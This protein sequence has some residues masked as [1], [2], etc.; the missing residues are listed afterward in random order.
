ML[1]T[2]P[3]VADP[4]QKTVLVEIAARL[5]AEEGEAGLTLRRLAK[6]AGTSTMAV[7]THFGGMDELR[8]EIRREAFDRFRAALT[9]VA[10]TRDP[11]FDLGMLGV[12]YMSNAM[13]NPNLYRAMFMEPV[14]AGGDAVGLDTFVLLVDAIARCQEKGRFEPGDSVA[15]AREVWALMHGAVAL[16]LCGEL[17]LDDLLTTTFNGALHQFMGFGDS[18]AAARRSMNKVAEATAPTL[19]A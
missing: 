15:R 9:S 17:G 16:F 2:V 3:R 14:P 11:V 5:L 19:P 10:T 6:E 4:E 1:S 18:A 12:A 13:A 8:V 7:Y